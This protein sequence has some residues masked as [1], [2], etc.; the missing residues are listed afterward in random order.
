[1]IKSFLVMFAG[2]CVA[3]TL[4]SIGLV[5]AV[6]TLTRPRSVTWTNNKTMDTPTMSYVKHVFFAGTNMT[7]ELGMRSDG[8]VVWRKVQE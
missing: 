1:M 8:V 5:Q 3:A 7:V 4:I 2:A 6:N